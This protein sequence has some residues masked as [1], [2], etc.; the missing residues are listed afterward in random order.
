MRRVNLKWIEWCLSSLAVLALVGGCKDSEFASRT[1]RPNIAQF[2]GPESQPSI[3]AVRWQTLDSGLIASICS[4]ASLQELSICGAA[5]DG[6][7]IFPQ[8]SKLPNLET[9]NIIEVHLD[10]EELRGLSE[11]ASL[12]SLELSR[13]GISGIGLQYIAKLSLK[14]LVIREQRLSF[15]GLQAIA[16]MTELEEL[17]LCIPGIHLADMPVLA[18]INKLK[19]V[20]I[21]DGHFSFREFGGLKFLMGSNS[22]TDLELSGVSLND[23]SLKSISTLTNLRNLTIGKSVIS[24]EGIGYLANLQ[25]LQSVDFPASNSLQNAVRLAKR[26]VEDELLPKPVRS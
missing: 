5:R 23:R 17:E 18:S 20:I 9:L 26:N 14:R 3:A 6:S 8:L 21:A 25:H 1:P 7:P 12:K 2:Y 24:E 19:S 13:T 11:V 4:Q 16:S 10:D 15:E 22:L